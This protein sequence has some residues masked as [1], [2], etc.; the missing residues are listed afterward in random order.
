[1]CF[2]GIKSGRDNKRGWINMPKIKAAGLCCLMAF[3]TAHPMF[4]N[5]KADV[6][7]DILLGNLW[8]QAIVIVRENKPHFLHVIADGTGGILFCKKR[9]VQLLKTVL[10]FCWKRYFAVLVFFSILIYFNE[11]IRSYFYSVRHLHRRCWFN[12]RLAEIRARC[13]SNEHLI[14]HYQ[15]YG[16][17]NICQHLFVTC[18]FYF[19]FAAAPVRPSMC[20]LKSSWSDCFIR[21]TVRETYP[22]T[23]SSLPVRRPE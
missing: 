21:G 23:G 17:T 4:F 22:S 6:T 2:A 16:Q 8:R 20:D 3:F 9:V 12:K 11:P 5:N 10:G 13:W 15:L 7:D 19:N 1:M 18:N 14:A